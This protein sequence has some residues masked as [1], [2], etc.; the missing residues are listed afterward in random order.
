MSSV[1]TGQILTLDGKVFAQAMWSVLAMR[2]DSA[3][4]LWACTA[5]TGWIPHC[6]QCLKTDE[7]ETALLA[8]NL[9]SGALLQRIDSPLPGMLGDM[10]LSRRGDIYVSEGIHGAVLRLPRGGTALQRPGQPGEFPSPQTP[11]LSADEKTLCVPDYV[12][13]IAAVNLQSA[14]VPAPVRCLQPADNIALSGIDGLYTYRGAF[15]AIQNGTNLARVIRFSQ[16]LQHQQILES[17]SPGLGEPTHGVLV[18]D[19]FYFLANT[20]WSQYDGQGRKKAG[21]APVE[22]SVRSLRLMK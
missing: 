13:G 19:R 5:C 2:A 4:I 16:D 18:N 21:T 8:F 10:T 22:S 15:I 3:R 7:G 9:D 17:N 14:T 11:A 1:R 20:G 6:E 12:R